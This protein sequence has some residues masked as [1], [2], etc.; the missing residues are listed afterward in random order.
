MHLT[1]LPFTEENNQLTYSQKINRSGIKSHYDVII[2][3]LLEKTR[4]VVAEEDIGMREERKEGERGKEKG[5][6]VVSQTHA[7]LSALL[8]K[9]LGV[10]NDD[11]KGTLFL[12]FFFYSFFLSISSFIFLL[13]IN[14]AEILINGCDSLAATQFVC[15]IK[16]HF[17]VDLPLNA[18]YTS[19]M[20]VFNKTTICF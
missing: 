9:T 8:K 10:E 18:L 14:N 11:I 17:K 3:T 1:P 13:F 12:L 2:T 15:Q 4:R 16:D 6:A 7:K 20:N 5:M 19:S